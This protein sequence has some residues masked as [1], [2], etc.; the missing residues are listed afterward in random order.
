M[1]VLW[2][3][4]FYNFL[5]FWYSYLNHT[6]L[7]IYICCSEGNK[8]WIG[9]VLKPLV[10]VN[11]SDVMAL[12]LPIDWVN[13]ISSSEENS[14]GDTPIKYSAL[15]S[16]LSRIVDQEQETA[17]LRKMQEE[18]RNVLNKIDGKLA[19]KVVVYDAPT[20]TSESMPITR[21][22]MTSAAGKSGTTATSVN[23]ISVWFDKCYV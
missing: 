8:K 22:K 10:D 6:I 9:K 2:F 11:Q 12:D 21:V 18:I 14:F 19:N 1:L 5:F 15:C 23:I 17:T 7:H 13:I 3:Y 4:F 20:A 16:E